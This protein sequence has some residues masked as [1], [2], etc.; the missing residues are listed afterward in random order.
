MSVVTTNTEEVDDNLDQSDYQKAGGNQ[1]LDSYYLKFLSR[2]QATGENQ[3]LRYSRWNDQVVPLYMSTEEHDYYE[4]HPISVCPRCQSIRKLELQIMPQLLYYLKVDT[5]MNNLD[6][7]DS[8]RS[9]CIDWGI[10]DIFTCTNSCETLHSTS[11]YVEEYIHV[12][13][14]VNFHAKRW[15]DEE[16][17]D[18]T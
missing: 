13:K 18:K 10:I 4:T 3:I 7:F 2:T 5:R 1:I 9:D 16:E 11:N 15:A 8:N 12:Q 17:E 6:E 14:P